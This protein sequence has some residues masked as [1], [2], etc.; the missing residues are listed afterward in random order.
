MSSTFRYLA[1]DDI[2]EFVSHIT[3]VLQTSVAMLVLVV[4]CIVYTV[5]TVL[6]GVTYQAVCACVRAC[7][8]LPR[9]VRFCTAIK[10][11]ELEAPNCAYMVTM[12]VRQ[13]IFMQIVNV[14]DLHFQGQRFDSWFI[15]KFI[16]DYLEIGDRSNIAIANTERHIFS[17]DWQIFK[18]NIGPFQTSVS[19]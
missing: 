18:Y 1:N 5:P 8:R 9:N 6:N 10:Q 15:G 7:I 17:F 4:D 13:P 19:M 11:L 12:Y 14:F 16:R 2:I 3:L